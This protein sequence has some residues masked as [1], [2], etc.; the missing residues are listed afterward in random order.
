MKVAKLLREAFFQ[1]IGYYPT[2]LGGL[3]FKCDPHHIKFWR[4]ASSGGWEP[5]T[6]KILSKFLNRNSVYYDIGSWIGPTAIFAAKICKKVVC[7]EPD[8][9]A[10]QYLLWNI[11]LN[12]LNNVL[13]VNAALSDRT[14]LTRMAS[15]GNILGDSQTSLLNTDSTKDTIDVL[16]FTWKNWMDFAKMETPAFLKI[17]IEGGEFAFLP[18]I[19]EYL[20]AHKPI[21]YLSTHAPYLKAHQRREQMSR[22]VEVMAIYNTCLNEHLEPVA[23]NEIISEDALEHFQSY[24]LLDQSADNWQS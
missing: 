2:S 18:T 15:F 17:D 5:Q 8:H 4:K 12:E 21:V 1:S 3:K 9:V 24:V 14:E 10:Y 7:F 6:Y 19:K 22:I 13:P 11:R 20:S 23:L 16:A